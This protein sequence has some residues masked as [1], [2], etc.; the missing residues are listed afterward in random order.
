MCREPERSATWSY[1]S[2]G[3]EFAQTDISAKFGN[4]WPHKRVKIVKISDVSKT[5]CIFLHGRSCEAWRPFWRTCCLR[6]GRN[7]KACRRIWWTFQFVLVRNYKNNRR[8][9]GLCRLII[10]GRNGKDCWCTRG[11]YQFIQRRNSFWKLP[12]TG[13]TCCLVLQGQNGKDCWRTGETW[14]VQTFKYDRHFGRT[15]GLFLHD[16]IGK[17]DQWTLPCT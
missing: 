5:Q 15:C 17:D 7:G 6:Q 1:V 12:T 11:T 13:G 10:Q 4:F 14:L 3:P 8:L 9:G 16:R 2:L